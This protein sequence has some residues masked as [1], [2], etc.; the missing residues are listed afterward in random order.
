MNYCI[1]CQTP[2]IDGD[3]TCKSCGAHLHVKSQDLK[4]IPRIV[5][6]KKGFKVVKALDYATGF[7]VTGFFICIFINLISLPF[8]INLGGSLFGFTLTS[9]L[10]I[11]LQKILKY[12][13]GIKSIANNLNRI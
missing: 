11:L 3:L 13:S 6:P 12:L 5:R 1:Y 8:F 9:I 2:N 4:I 7:L 10:S